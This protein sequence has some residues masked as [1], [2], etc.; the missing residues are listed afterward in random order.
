MVACS[1]RFLRVRCGRGCTNESAGPGWPGAVVRLGGRQQGLGAALA[2]YRGQWE[3]RR[4]QEFAAHGLDAAAQ[5][6]DLVQTAESMVRGAGELASGTALPLHEAVAHLK[7]GNDPQHTAAP[8]VVALGEAL[9][10][11]LGRDAVD[12]AA[13]AEKRIWRLLLLTQQFQPSKLRGGI[14]AARQPLLHLWV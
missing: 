5:F 2:I 7:D 9:Q 6:G 3:K 13:A 4:Q 10:Y 11:C 14:P 12:M 8:A 1:L